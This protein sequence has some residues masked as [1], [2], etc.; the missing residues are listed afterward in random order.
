MKDHIFN[1][2]QEKGDQKIEN[3]LIY[4]HLQTLLT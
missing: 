4:G 3:L 1:T 2:K